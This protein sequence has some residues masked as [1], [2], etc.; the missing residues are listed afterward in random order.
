M[1]SF[2]CVVFCL[3]VVSLS[4]FTFSSAWQSISQ[5]WRKDPAQSSLGERVPGILSLRGTLSLALSAPAAW[6]WGGVSRRETRAGRSWSFV[7]PELR[8]VPGQ[9]LGA[10]LGWCLCNDAHLMCTL[11][12]HSRGL[13]VRTVNFQR[14]KM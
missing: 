1:Y 4:H 6:A 11:F 8:T 2:S 14:N 3:F 9:L 7:F 5:T 10:R 12:P 13:N